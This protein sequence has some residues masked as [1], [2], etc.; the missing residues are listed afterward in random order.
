MKGKDQSEYKEKCDAFVFIQS[1]A[2]YCAFLF[3]ASTTT[4]RENSVDGIIPCTAPYE[5]TK[6][7]TENGLGSV[8]SLV[9]CSTSRHTIYQC[10]SFI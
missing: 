6:I 5:G 4:A 10:I 2:K 1:I 7:M 9:L 3:P 8:R